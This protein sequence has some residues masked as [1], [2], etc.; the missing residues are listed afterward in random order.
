[1]H[2]V[3]VKPNW[4]KVSHL[5]GPLGVEEIFEVPSERCFTKTVIL[6]EFSDRMTARRLVGSSPTRA[7]LPTIEQAFRASLA[8][9]SFPKPYSQPGSVPSVPPDLF[10]CYADLWSAHLDPNPRSQ[11]L[12]YL[13]LR[14][15][16]RDAGN[17]LL[18][19]V[20]PEALA[21]QLEFA[22]GFDHD[23]GS[24]ATA[25]TMLAATATGFPLPP[26]ALKLFLYL[27]L[28]KTGET[29]NLNDALPRLLVPPSPPGQLTPAQATEQLF[30][31]A[32]AA[33]LRYNPAH[34]AH[35][36]VQATEGDFEPPGR[37]LHL[38]L[39]RERL[40]SILPTAPLSPEAP[41]KA[42]RGYL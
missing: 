13:W 2:L 37:F 6:S 7:G 11:Q 34:Q 8:D 40:E 17:R 31:Q 41:P 35:L 3:Q 28:A 25:L 15:D 19:K 26:S 29:Y 9:F 1:M 27:P 38:L 36:D 10:G 39:E 18:H 23:S 24:F 32:L 30:N 33:G 4:R 20:I 22:I 42:P 21:N 16:H 5:R 12:A 14:R